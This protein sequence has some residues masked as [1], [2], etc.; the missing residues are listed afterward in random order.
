[1]SRLFDSAHLSTVAN[2]GIFKNS[3]FFLALQWSIF[4][5]YMK[6]NGLSTPSITSVVIPS[7]MRSK[8]SYHRRFW[9]SSSPFSSSLDRILELIIVISINENTVRTP[10]I[11]TLI[12]PQI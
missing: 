3:A 1:M 11:A 5:L 7:S 12:S 8:G 6:N 9:P 10:Y 4:H 2:G